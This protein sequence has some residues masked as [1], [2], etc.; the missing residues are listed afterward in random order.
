MTAEEL[1]R[2]YDES[3]PAILYRPPSTGATAGTPGTFTPANTKPPASVADLI[4]GKPNAVTAS[5]ATAWTTGQYVQTRTAGAAG[6]A[7]WNGTAWVS[8]VHA[9]QAKASDAELP[10][11][12]SDFTVAEVERWVTDN[13]DQAEQVFVA[14][15]DRDAPRT[16]LVAWLESFMTS[17]DEE[18]D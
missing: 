17:R 15:T 16:T 2:Y 11:D 12:V 8:G 9:L 18:G 13:P 4:A 6:Q 14:E 3:L 1:S 7:N 10:D 5:P